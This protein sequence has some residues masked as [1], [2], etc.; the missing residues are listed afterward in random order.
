M[1]PL[2]NKG[3][4]P[5]WCPIDHHPP[6]ISALYTNWDRNPFLS[7]TFQTFDKYLDAIAVTA[8]RDVASSDEPTAT[9]DIDTFLHC[10]PLPRARDTLKFHSSNSYVTR[11]IDTAHSNTRHAIPGL[12]Q[13]HMSLPFVALSRS[14]PK[15]RLDNARF[16][17]AL[18]SK[19]RV[20]HFPPSPRQCASATSASNTTA[21]TSSHAANSR[22]H[23]AAMVFDTRHDT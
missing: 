12:L 13:S 4:P 10:L 5:S 9:H 20:A 1:H 3:D 15:H 7:P 6:A 23:A 8:V 22:R 2:H 16:V 17:T 19:L 11:L 18:K 14:D 21:I